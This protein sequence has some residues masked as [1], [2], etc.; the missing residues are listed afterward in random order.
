MKA[1][2]EAT[3]AARAIAVTHQVRPQLARRAILRDLLEKIVVRVEEEAEPGPKLIDFE[4]PLERPVNIFES[5]PQR[6]RKLL[7]G[8]GTRLADMISADRNGVETGYAASSKF[9]RVRDQ[10]HRGARRKDVLL[11]RDVLFQ[12]VVLKRAGE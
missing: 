3:F 9:H 6:E 2:L 5:I 7:R 10:P 12:N 8:S 4:A 1:Q 11:L